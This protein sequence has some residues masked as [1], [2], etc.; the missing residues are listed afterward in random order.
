MHIHG[1]SD[2]RSSL[3]ALP[4]R[5]KLLCMA[6]VVVAVTALLLTTVPSHLPA[7]ASPGGNGF[8][9]TQ[10]GAVRG[11]V[12]ETHRE[13]AG[14][15][16]AAP[17]VGDLRWRAPQPV[18]PWTGIR[19][20]TASG[21]RCVQ[22]G[23][24]DESEDCLHLN[25]WTPRDANPGSGLPV[26]VYIHG[27]AYRSGS[28][29]SYEP[30]S[31]VN[32]GDM[33]VVTINY[34]LGAMGFLTTPELDS[35]SG[36]LSGNYGLLDQIQ[37]LEWVQDNIAGFGGDP[38]RVMVAGQSAGGESVCTLLASPQAAGLFTTA[39]VQS[40]LSCGQGDRAITQ[41]NHADF[42]AALGCEHPSTN[43]VVDCLYEASPDEVLDAQ[44]QAGSVWYPTDDH[45]AMPIQAEEAFESGN[46]NQ[47]PVMIGATSEEGAFFVGRKFDRQGGIT[48]EGFADAVATTFGDELAEDILPLYPLE[49]DWLSPGLAESQMKTDVAFSCPMMEHAAN[50][51]QV[52]PAYLYE[53]RDETASGHDYL[54]APRHGAEVRYL[55]ESVSDLDESQQPLANA[56]IDY[57]SEFA[58]S[59]SPTPDG[60]PAPARYSA[61]TADALAFTASGP[62][63]V[64]DMNSVHQCDFWNSVF[65][66]NWSFHFG[67]GNPLRFG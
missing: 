40:G 3:N 11:F 47:V 39:V 57:W 48:A 66:D 9:R 50:I 58:R 30:V 34:R 26:A 54:G 19:E 62:E 22:R 42:V 17:P 59:G 24:P 2:V 49:D 46:F 4:S 12:T 35:S 56:M 37:A 28:G 20:A 41:D 51:N 33:V 52:V 31:M 32:R 38:D 67:P 29:S 25:V 63:I 36:E 1:R 13:F 21:P 15:P 44:G 8:V 27:G 5:S 45:P 6:A 60:L 14:I 61:A 16:Y 18:E 64:D 65:P 7:A 10:D 55:W 53:F 43:E 23:N